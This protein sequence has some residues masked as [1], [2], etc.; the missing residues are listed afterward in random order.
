[1]YWDIISVKAESHLTIVVKFADGLTGKVI[2]KPSH[3]K[4]VFVAL[5]DQEYFN[6]VYVKH[7]AATWPGEL[8]IAPDAMHKAI[9]AN[10]KWMLD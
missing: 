10:G 2:F 4:G 9:K 1:M 8:D 7:G 3:L 6:K 5:K